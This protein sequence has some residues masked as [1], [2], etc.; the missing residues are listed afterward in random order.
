MY[1]DG[2]GVATNYIKSYMWWSVAKMQGYQDAAYNIDI[3]ED[4]MTPD[5]IAIAQELASQW[6]EK[7]SN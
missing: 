4:Q 1:F 7:Y 3:V 5:Q 6:W 2:K